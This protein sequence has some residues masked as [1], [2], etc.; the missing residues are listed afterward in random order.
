VETIKVSGNTFANTSGIAIFGEKCTGDVDL[1]G[2]TIAGGVI[3]IDVNGVTSG[4]RLFVESNKISGLTGGAIRLRSVVQSFSISGNKISGCADAFQTS[5]ATA[6]SIIKNNEVAGA[7]GVWTRTGTYNGLQYD[8]N[9]TNI[10]VAFSVRTATIASD[11]IT[12]TMDWHWVETEGAAAADD[13]S[14]INGG[15]EG[16]RLVLFAANNGR[17]VVLKDGVGNMRLNGDFTLT[18]SDDSVELIFRN[19]VWI[20]VSRSDNT[21]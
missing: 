18:H 11:A 14:T 5:G 3:G 20:E 4:A 21:A 9:A 19:N 6:F 8:G 15:Y 7:T 2:N 17:D 16:R 1:S 10:G 13:L 12:A